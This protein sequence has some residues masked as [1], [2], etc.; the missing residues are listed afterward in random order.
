MKRI[1]RWIFNGL[2]VLSLLVCMVLMAMDIR[3]FWTDDHIFHADEGVWHVA[4][5]CS[6][7]G[8]IDF[9]RMRF[10]D[11]PYGQHSMR[12]DSYYD[13]T[14]GWGW[15]HG[16][17][18]SS[19][20]WREMLLG[21]YQH[22][23]QLG[24]DSVSIEVPYWLFIVLSAILPARWLIIRRRWQRRQ[25]AGLCRRCGYDLRA[26]PDRCPECGNIP[27]NRPGI[28]KSS[29]TAIPDSGG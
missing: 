15:S 28:S 18:W 24:T 4:D 17:P 21:D 12:I 19:W 22:D 6:I 16:E 1:W 27:E 25:R 10:T 3:S 2:A 13:V 23:V 8:C 11:P 9:E 29:T 5:L 14:P 7:S 26:T 20:H